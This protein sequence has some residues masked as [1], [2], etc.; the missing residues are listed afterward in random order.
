QPKG[1]CC[2]PSGDCAV[3]T[4]PTCLGL[5]GEY[6]GVGTVCVEVECDPAKG[7]CCLPSGGCIVTRQSDC[8]NAGGAYQG[9]FVQCG[10]VECPQP[11]GACCLENGSCAVVTS[12]VCASMGGIYQGNLTTCVGANCPDPKGGCCLPNGTCQVVS[13][14]LCAQ[15]GGLYQGDFSTCSP[16]PCQGLEGACCLVATNSCFVGTAAECAASG[17]LYQG[18]LTTCQTVDC[19]EPKGACCLTDGTCVSTTAVECAIAG[20]VY[21]GNLVLCADVDCDVVGGCCF[22]DAPCTIMF[23]ADCTTAGGEYLGDDTDCMTDSYAM[24]FSTE[25]DFLTPL[26]NGQFVEEGVAFGEL[27]SL[28]STGANLGVAV[29]DTTMGGVNSGG[30]DPDLLVGLGNALILQSQDNPAMS[31]NVF[32]TP[33]DEADPGTMI[34][35][36]HRAATV[37]SLDLIDLCPGPGEQGA[38]VT[39][40]D[41]A[42]LTRAYTVPAGFTRDIA[43]QGPL[44]YDTLDLTT[45]SPQLGEGGASAT[46][47]EEIGFNASNVGHLRVKFVS[48]GAVDNVVFDL[49]PC[50]SYACG[51][52]CVPGEGCITQTWKTCEDDL[53]GD[54]QGDYSRCI[55]MWG[56]PVC[57]DAP[58]W[59][60]VGCSSSF[61]L[62]AGVQNAWPAGLSPD[63]LFSAV[64]VDVFPDVTLA[65]ALAL[66]DDTAMN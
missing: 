40:V 62:Q 34:F 22:C 33:N 36:F 64:F 44:G 23:E 37:L 51:A 28:T 3:V 48:S 35:T 21:Q 38:T 55:D 29:F 11:K 15:L 41:R 26:V 53:D 7:A 12:S 9:D 65:E 52:C 59:Q 18:D 45:L 66:P 17:G 14:A 5:G 8:N 58:D 32:T 4:Q 43:S 61:W 57:N 63:D 60:T 42:G 46:A 25:D 39:L 24:D 27:F 54:Y 10:E 47:V 20:G 30:P 56:D 2:L 16:N 49:G 19:P 31:G 6:A 50:P 13:Q 1:A